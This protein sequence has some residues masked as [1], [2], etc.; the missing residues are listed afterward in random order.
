[1]QKELIL[2]FSFAALVACTSPAKQ[3]VTDVQPIC[4]STLVLGES[5]TAEPLNA[6]RY[7][8]TIE[9]A[10]TTSVSMQTPGRV[11]KVYCREGDRV[12]RNQ[13]LLRI[14]NTQA[15]NAL[16]SAEATLRQAQDGYDR[17]KKVH[18]QGAVTDQQMVEIESRLAQAKS[19]RDAAQRQ[20]SECELRA[21]AD[22]VVSQLDIAEGQ[23]V[24]PGVRLMTLLD[25]SAY[26]VSF[27]VPETEIN[28]VSIGQE[29]EVECVA[30]DSILPC[31]ITDLGLQANPLAHTYTVKADI[32][33][34]RD[35]LRHGMVGKV[36][37]TPNPL[38][39]NSSPLII[40]S[41]CVHLMQRGPAVWRVKNG[42]ADRVLIQVNGYRADGVL[43]SDGLQPGDTLI[44]DGYQ[45]L[46]QGAP[47]TL[48][49][50]H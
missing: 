49:T 44:T 15:L 16:H 32:R 8:G 17:V 33:G 31:K 39:V 36:L 10:H 11:L 22:G 6:N 1:M 12:R 38:T 25:P 2:I 45:K 47:L 13:I 14:D 9:A 19:L 26:V 18:A 7:V 4:V 40:P 20:V 43:V 23:T 5:R 24:V 46:Y 48:N 28:T 37:L 50:K 35:C 41:H 27:S 29:G 42:H 34:G 3:K 21:P 30:L